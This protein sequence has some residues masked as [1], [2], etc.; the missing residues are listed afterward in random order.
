MCAPLILC[1]I[2]RVLIRIT[3]Y[4]LVQDLFPDKVT[5]ILTTPFPSGDSTWNGR[6]GFRIE[7]FKN[8]K[9]HTRRILRGPASACMALS[10]VFPAQ[11]GPSG[12]LASSRV[13]K[14]L[15]FSD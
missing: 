13:L 14:P 2:D 4:P 5:E 10:L 3:C 15:A 9:V 1:C 11:G 7:Y 8:Y 12:V 6:P